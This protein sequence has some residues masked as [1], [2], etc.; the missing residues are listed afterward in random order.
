MVIYTWQ[1]YAKK[2]KEICEKKVCIKLCDVE[3]ITEVKIPKKL[4]QTKKKELDKKKKVI[5]KKEIVKPKEQK[6][7]LVKKPVKQN[8]TIQKIKP[9]IQKPITKPV[10]EAKPR[11]VPKPVIEEPIVVKPTVKVVEPV[12]LEVKKKAFIK[13]TEKPQQV[14]EQII[15]TKSARDEYFDINKA[16]IRE[17][18]S[19]NLY[20][21]RRA[22]K[23]HITG[24]VIVKFLLD[25]DA[26][27]SHVEVESSKSKILSKAAIQTI[28]DLS[29]RFPKPKEKITLHLPIGFFL[30]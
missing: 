22:R 21:P 9:E 2:P 17:L 25:I 15:F 27:V 13:K 3:C 24:D 16:K 29:G 30:K 28:E 7:K 4:Q 12:K 14:S 6:K 26:T 11:V 1:D 8:K 19:E 18:I 23:K 20:Y 5:T 10:V